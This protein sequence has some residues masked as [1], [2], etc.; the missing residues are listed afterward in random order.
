MPERETIPTLPVRCICPGIMPILHA[1][2]V[3]M[4]GQLG[5]INRL[6]EPSSARL[7]RTIS[8]TGMPSVIQT[9]SATSA[10]IASNIASA[11]KAAGT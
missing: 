1:P 3:M 8:S 10:S 5:P 11:A 7:T 2:G 6:V 9:I 4:P